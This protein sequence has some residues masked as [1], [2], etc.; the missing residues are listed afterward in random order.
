MT[1]VSE[2]RQSVRA[3]GIRVV[4]VSVL[5]NVI[6][7]FY[8]NAH[9]VVAPDIM[10]DTGATAQTLGYLSGA[11]FVTAAILQIPAGLLLDRYG[12]RRTMPFMLLTVVVGSV[13]FAQA[14]TPAGLIL[15]RIVMGV[16]V[17]AIGMGAIV[18]STRWFTPAYFATVV[19]I[20]LGLSYLGTIG[21]TAPMAWASH[22][23]G[24]RNSYIV[25]AFFTGALVIATLLFV[26]DAPAGHA[27]HDRAPES[28]AMAWK[29]VR[30]ILAVRELWPLLV[31]AGTAYAVV[32]CILGLWGGAYLYDIYGLDPASRGNV[33]IWFPVGMLI[34]NFV[35][36]PLDRILDTRKR[37]IMTCAAGTAVI[38]L[39]LAWQP[40]MPLVA[41]T[42]AFA[43]IGLLTAYTTVIIAHGRCFYPDR[44]MGR[45]VTVVNTAVLAGAGVMQALTG[46]VAGIMAPGASNLSVDIYRVIFM[47]LA[48]ILA[49]SLFV[50][51]RCPDVPPSQGAHD[52]AA[53]STA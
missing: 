17:A 37:I 38:F 7:Q 8:R 15:S 9:V 3:T 13:M 53:A 50:Y 32:S 23:I 20:I 22:M 2:S 36:T 40:R 1:A 6:S 16:G 29:G 26:R 46:L 11:L 34:G 47:L 33:M 18:A 42:I 10:A 43:L 30:D 52:A 39:L 31:L 49:F 25:V 51:R 27:F 28:L 14:E 48:I 24:W 5:I 45:G 44:L 19:G 12:P 41:V 35:I 21:A 4:A